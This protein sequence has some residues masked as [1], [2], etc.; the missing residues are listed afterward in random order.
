[1]FDIDLHR[2][3]DALKI[4]IEGCFIQPSIQ[5]QHLSGA[6]AIYQVEQKLKAFFNK[7]FALTFPSAT[8]ALHTLCLA[9]DLVNTQIL[10][11]PINW[12]GGI[13]PFL[14]HNNKLRFCAFDPLTLNMS[15]PNLFSLPTNNTKAVLSVDFNGWPVDSQQIKIFCEKNNMLYL[16]D[17]SQSMG[18]L[19]NDKPAG[20]YA[21]AIVL[22]FSPGKSFFAG[23]GGA[24]VTDDAALYEKLIR[25]SQHP[26][27]Q[28][29]VL[30]VN[31]FN[32][33]APV[34][35]RM[36]PLSAILLNETF[37]VALKALEDY[38]NLCYNLLVAL[39]KNEF[40]TNSP[41][42]LNSKDSTFFRFVVKLKP[43]VTPQ[44]VNEFLTRHQFPFL[45]KHYLP[46][47]IP[48]DP[49]FKQQ[50]KRHY[51]CSDALNVQNK[52][53]FLDH[54]VQLSYHSTIP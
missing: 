15:L 1:M 21:D 30:G 4:Y 27:R 11:S 20:Y 18:A 33:Y 45:A 17:C 7:K 40:I 38:Q 9:M 12:G 54:Y 42:I 16:S 29:T 51:S 6:G 8:T 41:H 37:E 10:T 46:V 24:I 13:A 53:N 22:S 26:L 36:N 32:S 35:G 39:R 5:F 25:Y 47:I 31:N 2:A 34:N 19:F 23:E 28:K 49:S 43:S 48:F 50:F 52:K 14:F 3:I 44:D